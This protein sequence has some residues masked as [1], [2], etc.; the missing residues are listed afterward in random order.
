VAFI[1][2]IWID[3]SVHETHSVGAEVSEHPVEAGANIADHIRPLPR[4][5]TIEGMVTNFPIEL[6]RSHAGAARVAST[7][8]EIVA[9]SDPRPR[10]SPAT[11]QIEG[12]PSVGPLGILP[13][14]GQAVAILGALKLD[15]R[16]KEQF[17]A[18]QFNVDERAT[19][20]YAANVLHFTEPFNRVRDVHDALLRIVETSQLV[21]VVTGLI[22]YNSVA[23]TDLSVE[24]SGALGA[25]M[26]KF[27]AVG[28]VL[29]IVQS[30]T[31][32][33]P[34]PIDSRAKGT[35]SRGK[36]ATEPAAGLIPLPDDLNANSSAAHNL[37]SGG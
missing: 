9:A 3:V 12:E 22:T 35:K 31:A 24:R 8:I 14:V 23:L 19:T 15:V 17:A 18:Q 37:F 4:A 10:V 5:I 13:G 6:P 32:K 16:S 33:L 28:K 36:Q 11:V 1:G 7:S 27:T 34:D 30:Q 21:T 26:L 29:R 2:D 25:D 20:T